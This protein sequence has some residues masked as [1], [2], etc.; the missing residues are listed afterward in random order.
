MKVEEVNPVK[1][2]PRNKSSNK[3]SK[4]DK[5]KSIV[6]EDTPTASYTPYPFV[7]VGSDNNASSKDRNSVLP[8]IEKRHGS[9]TPPSSWKDDPSPLTAPAPRHGMAL[10]R[11]LAPPLPPSCPNHATAWFSPVPCP[12]P[13][14]SPSPPS[15]HHA[16][17]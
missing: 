15:L 3:K 16:K 11:S 12:F 5:D 17:A 8:K 9:T 2:A 1:K 10:A 4:E 13:S 6:F 14:P 7:L